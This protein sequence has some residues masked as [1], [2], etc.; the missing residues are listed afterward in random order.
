EAKDGQPRARELL[1]N[2][3]NLGVTAKLAG[4]SGLIWVTRLSDGQPQAGAA[5]T[6]RDAKGKVR[7]HGTTDADG[8]AITPGRAQLLPRKKAS[9]E[10]PRPDFV[11]Q[12][13]DGADD[14][15]EGDF[16]GGDFT[17]QHAA[18]LLVFARVG[19]DVTW[20]NPTRVGGLASWNFH[21]TGDQ[22]SR[23][24]E[25]R[26]F[27]H[28]DRGLYRPGDT[29]HLRGLARTMKL[30]SALRIPTAR[31][32]AVSVRD[33]R[34]EEILSK[35]V[36]LSRYGGFSFDVPTSAGARLGDYRV[37]ASLGDAAFAERFSIEQYRAAAFEVK[38]PLPPR[39]PIAGESIELTAEA[40]YLYGAPLRSGALTWRVY[41]RNRP[42]AFPKLSAFDF[43][44]ARTWYDDYVS[45]SAMSESLVREDEQKLD[46]DGRARIALKLDKGD[47]GTAQDLMVTAE[48][49]DETHQTIAANIAV[50]AHPA[51][52]YFGID[53]GSPIGGSGSGRTIKIVAVDP[54]G[55]RIAA[56]ATLRIQKRDWSCAWEAW[57][58][59][60][61]YRCEKKEPE[62]LRQAIA[63]PAG[64]PAE[65]RFAPPSPGEYFVIVEGTDGA[66]NP[67]ASASELWTWGD[68]EAAWQAEDNER[69]DVIA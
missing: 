66:G 41:R 63:I 1:L 44:D 19:N 43:G 62:V 50:P 3:T 21:V 36:P 48:V 9:P 51:A 34:G 16:D 24:E 46:K 17:E 22:S 14:E 49:Q 38:V 23:T 59:Q 54:K 31:K 53:R 45:R 29:V 60:G 52:V 55:E 28:S 26:G 57:G 5:I 6:I 13:G 42:V 40:R 64:A 33:P 47:F 20:V 18:D 25:L 10:A 61:S 4:P 30:G 37:T 12:N 67:T 2:F 69:F 32:V 39:E 35:K 11:G 65:V 7:W 58:Y 8:V 56:N 27:L 68:G 15:G